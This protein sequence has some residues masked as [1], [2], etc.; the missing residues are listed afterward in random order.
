MTPDPSGDQ[1]VL[2]IP[3]SFPGTFMFLQIQRE[4]SFVAWP[5][6]PSHDGAGAALTWFRR[7]VRP[8]GGLM[9]AGGRAVMATLRL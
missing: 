5:D 9:A 4:I 8:C 1:E 2:G 7:A 3:T 6:E